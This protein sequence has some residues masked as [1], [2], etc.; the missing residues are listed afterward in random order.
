M[1]STLVFT[2]LTAVLASLSSVAM[3]QTAYNQISF[4]SE[5]RTK[6]ANDQLQATLSKTAQAATPAAI[7]N[8]LS[9]SINQALTLAK[10]YPEVVVST[11]RQHTQPRYANN[12]DD[13]DQKIIGF[14]GSVS[15]ELSS[16]NFER[17]SQ[18]IADL[19]NIMIIDQ[20]NFGVS[21][22]T[23]ANAEKQLQTQ[24]IKN[25]QD[26][27]Q[28]ISQSFGASGYKIVNVQLNHHQYTPAY[29]MAMA[30][31]A[32][33]KMADSRAVVQEFSAGDST[34]NYTINGTIELI[35]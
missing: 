23:Y 31:M 32:S 3:A 35:K 28:N 22:Q 27:A 19:Q 29:P 26:E 16:K 24:A 15:L 14:T 5:A 13:G 7:A 20:L 21:E 9:K 10:R 11:S 8:E 2:T 1:K 30:M 33:A 17:A 34:I 4:T 6:I 18:L 12:Q 25:F